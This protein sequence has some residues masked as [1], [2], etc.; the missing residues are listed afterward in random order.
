MTC[1][2]LA[3]II[4]DSSAEEKEANNAGTRARTPFSM[5]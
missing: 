2:S 5:H 4:I 1:V 3:H